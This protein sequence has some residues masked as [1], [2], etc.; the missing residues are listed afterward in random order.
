MYAMGRKVEESP[1]RVRWDAVRISVW[2]LIL[3]WLFRT[4]VKLLIVIVR[5]PDGD[6]RAVADRDH[7]AGPSGVRAGS[8]ADGLRVPAAG[9]RAAAVAAAGPVR[10]VRVPG[11]PVAVA[12]VRAVPVPVA[13]VDGH[14]RPQPDPR[15]A[16]VP[17]DVEVGEV[18]AVGGSGAGADAAR[19]DGR[20]LGQGV[21]PAVPDLRRP[22]LPRPH[23]EGPAARARAVVPGRRPAGRTG[24][25]AAGQD[26]VNLDGL[27][28][29]RCEDGTVYRLKLRGNHVLCAGATGAGKGSV[30]WSA[31]ARHG[32]AELPASYPP[33]GCLGS[34]GPTHKPD[35]ITYTLT[36]LLSCRRAA[37]LASPV[38]PSQGCGGSACGQPFG[39]RRRPARPD[40]F[41][42]ARP[43]PMTRQDPGRRNGGQGRAQRIRRTPAGALDGRAGGPTLTRSGEAEH[44]NHRLPDTDRKGIDHELLSS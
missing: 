20:G 10:A 35:P 36:L 1:I 11:G 32:T 31:H 26:P 21:G 28:V 41:P 42:L 5:S 16:A 15:R 17:P 38:R 43:H 37:T 23:R 18:D 9:D 33:M 34:S 22:G 14:R 44:P 12:A 4:V 29:G 8:G 13:G 39:N 27:P 19:P 40:D 3:G 24:R 25:A 30:L 6:L 2:A 7:L